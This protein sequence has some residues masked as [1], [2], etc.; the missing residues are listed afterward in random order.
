MTSYSSILISIVKYCICTLR[1]HLAFHNFVSKLFE[2]V[3]LQQ[4]S[5]NSDELF[6]TRKAALVDSR[7]LSRTL[8]TKG[9]KHN[10]VTISRGHCAKGRTSQLPL[11][12]NLAESSKPTRNDLDQI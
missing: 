7:N 9:H 6:D 10:A 3:L 2:E 8:A 4:L 5:H 1:N 11:G 12:Q